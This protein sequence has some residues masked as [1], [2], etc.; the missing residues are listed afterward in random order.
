MVWCNFEAEDEFNRKILTDIKVF[1]ASAKKVIFQKFWRFFFDE[2]PGAKRF[3]HLN[4]LHWRGKNITAQRIQQRTHTYTTAPT[5]TP[6]TNTRL[7]KGQ[8]QRRYF[9]EIVNKG[10][11]CRHSA[12]HCDRYQTIR[13]QSTLSCLL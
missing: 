5:T 10:A 4:I 2:S 9:A 8:P 13:G 7:G 6:T 12:L 1:Q 11:G 3:L